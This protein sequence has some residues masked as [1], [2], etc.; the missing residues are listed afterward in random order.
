MEGST[1][2]PAKDPANNEERGLLHRAILSEGGV[3]EVMKSGIALEA[4]ARAD[5]ELFLPVVQELQ[6]SADPDIARRAGLMLEVYAD[7]ATDQ[8]PRDN[9]AL[10][11]LFEDRE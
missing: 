5:V 1:Y 4:L 9:P 7:L 6:Q 11:A 2:N 10:Q 8:D 3:S